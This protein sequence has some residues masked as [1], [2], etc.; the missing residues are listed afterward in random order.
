M[1][2]LFDN[3][4]SDRSEIVVDHFLEITISVRSLLLTINSYP[5]I[6]TRLPYSL[7]A[8]QVVLCPVP[9]AFVS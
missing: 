6:S 4:W 1:N 8:P 9:N 7:L 5:N 3:V 2:D